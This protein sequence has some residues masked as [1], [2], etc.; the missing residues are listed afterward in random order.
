M[1][2]H[3]DR[4]ERKQ[5]GV[6]IGEEFE[7]LKMRVHGRAGNDRAR[8]QEQ[9]QYNV[10]GSSHRR[11]VTLIAIVNTSQSECLQ[12]GMPNVPKCHE[13]RRNDDRPHRRHHGNDEQN[14]QRDKTKSV[15]WKNIRIEMTAYEDG[16]K[17][18]M[19]ENAQQK[20]RPRDASAVK[21]KTIGVEGRAGD[22]R[23]DEQ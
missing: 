10:P 5:H 4:D 21:P 22:E 3:R 7:F 20:R 16:K 15:L 6:D 19:N 1:L 18:R 14:G 8:I 11:V 13:D 2:L 12:C 17:M 9:I 23:S